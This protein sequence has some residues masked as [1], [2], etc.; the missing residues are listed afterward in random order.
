MVLIDKHS[1]THIN[2]AIRELNS[3]DYSRIDLG[4]IRK[5]SSQI[6][7]PPPCPRARIFRPP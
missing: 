5:G 7:T 6:F 2:K 1:E 3:K 4:A